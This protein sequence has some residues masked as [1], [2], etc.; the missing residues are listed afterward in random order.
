MRVVV[1]SVFSLLAE[2]GMRAR[3]PDGQGAWFSHPVPRP[4]WT[5]RRV[6]PLVGVMRLDVVADVHASEPGHRW[7]GVV[8]ATGRCGG[9]G[10]A[11]VARARAVGAVA[12]GLHGREVRWCVGPQGGPVRERR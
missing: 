3:I 2:K 7:F 12:G 6:V 10:L 11:G 8:C 9:R 4:V 1:S 5:I